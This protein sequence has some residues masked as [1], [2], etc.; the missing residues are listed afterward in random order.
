[1]NDQ[2]LFENSRS[3][4]F[5]DMERVE[6]ACRRWER[7]LP[8]INRPAYGRNVSSRMIRT[9]KAAAIE[10]FQSGTVRNC[11]HGEMELHKSTEKRPRKVGILRIEIGDIICCESIISADITI[12]LPTLIGENIRLTGIN[13]S[14]LKY[15]RLSLVFPA[16]EKWD[17]QLLWVSREIKD[18]IYTPEFRTNLSEIIRIK[19]HKKRENCYI[20]KE[21]VY[22]HWRRSG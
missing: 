17:K 6:A 2:K 13:I 11:L 18:R 1:M 8:S 14:E 12:T 10:A 21:R 7:D 5:K 22:S 16:S 15:N 4:D 19:Y 20:R 9:S 3:G